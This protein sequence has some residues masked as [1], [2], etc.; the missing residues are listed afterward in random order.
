[1]TDTHTRDLERRWLSV[2]SPSAE[3]AW[4]AARLRE[5]TLTRER[6][7]AACCLGSRGAALL[8]DVPPVPRPSRRTLRG[9]VA[10]LTALGG[11]M[12]WRTT[13]AA[14]E[15]S[16]AHVWRPI[17]RDVQATVDWLGHPER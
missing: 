6:V 12:T 8:E 11:H 3:A 13:L 16:L 2:G 14:A 1:M 10:A 7:R 17:P 15:V 5:G 4:L 9:W